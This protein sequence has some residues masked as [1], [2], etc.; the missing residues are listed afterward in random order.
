[1]RAKKTE[2]EIWNREAIGISDAVVGLKGSPTVVK[3]IF[4]P[5]Q[6]Q[7][8]RTFHTVEEGVSAVV[9]FLKETHVV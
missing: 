1:M 9:A 6:R 5:P 7:G 3:K 2:I 4:V 8:G